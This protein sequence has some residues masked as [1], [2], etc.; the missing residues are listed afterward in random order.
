M[1][2]KCEEISRRAL[3]QGVE[4]NVGAME[5]LVFETVFDLELKGI[6]SEE[7]HNAVEKTMDGVMTRLGLDP[8]SLFDGDYDDYDDYSDGIDGLLSASDTA[9]LIFSEDKDVKEA[10][11]RRVC[12]DDIPSL[13]RCPGTVRTVESSTG[14]SMILS[15][16]GKETPKWPNAGKAINEHKMSMPPRM[17]LVTEDGT[18]AMRKPMVV[19]HTAD[20]VLMISGLLSEV[21]EKEF[22]KRASPKNLHES[23][24]IE[25]SWPDD[26]PKKEA[27]R[28]LWDRFVE[29]RE[30]YRDAAKQKKGMI[31][32]TMYN[33]IDEDTPEPY[34]IAEWDIVEGHIKKHLGET[35]DGFSVDMY[36]NEFFRTP[37]NI[38]IIP[39]AKDRKSIIA[40]TSGAGV[41]LMDTDLS[42]R[43]ERA[44]F[45]ILLPPDW[46]CEKDDWPVDHLLDMAEAQVSYAE[47]LGP[48]HI[49]PNDSENNA[50]AKNTKLC[51]SM[52][53]VPRVFSDDA[54]LCKLP[55]G[56]EVRFWQAVPLYASEMEYAEENGAE[57]LEAILPEEAFGPLN[58]KRKKAV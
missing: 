56:D 4:K 52:L 5:R 55:G 42:E 41:R 48:G 46:D 8:I 40:V 2:V 20:D 26:E 14:V 34:S 16:Y 38:F 3:K 10:I 44:E 43:S 21:T 57:A 51:G 12:G 36:L 6:P 25:D 35:D 22:L 29:L 11:S 53:A 54:I 1:D 24:W 18:I 19:C 39:P 50:F 15:N 32:M 27:P 23:G 17:H 37:V 49:E 33:L 58:L 13:F 31:A 47:H 7:I 9:Y 28:Y 30:A 45:M